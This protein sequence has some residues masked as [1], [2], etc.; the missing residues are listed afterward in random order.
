MTR[1]LKPAA[2]LLVTALIVSACRG[3]IGPATVTP[4]IPTARPAGTAAFP[5]AEGAGAEAVG[6]RGGRVIEVTSL[7]DIGAGTLREAIEA[8]GPRIVVFRVGGII[9]LARPLR[10]E[11]PYLTIAGQTAPGGGITL[12][13]T[14]DGDGEM[15]IIQNTH[16]IVIRYLRIRRGGHGEPGHGQINI[17]VESGAHDVMVDHVSV[18]WTLDEN[19]AVFRNI[20]DDA[21][22]A[23]WPTIYNV[24]LQRSIMAE[25]L[26]PH[27]KGTQFG[28]EFEK[29]GWEGVYDITVHHNLYA[30]NSHRNP[31]VG[32]ARTQV[33]NNVVYN[34][35]TKLGETITAT[36]ADWIGNYFKPGPLS[37]E[38]RLL[39]HNAF[40]KGFPD[41]PYP[42]P[43]LYVA[44]NASPPLFSD[45][46]E[47]NW[48]MYRIHYA[49][50]PI[51]AEFRRDRPLP[52]LPIPVS[53][54]P[55]SEA[56]TSVLADSGANARLD[57]LGRW[58][59]NADAVDTR[60]VG[61]VTSNT[62]VGG[63]THV[64]HED[65]VGGYPNIE[66]GTACPDGDHD[67]MPD[68]WESAH[69][70]TDPDSFDAGE[71][72]LDPVYT[73]IEVLLNGALPEP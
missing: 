19:I 35:G 25:G 32:S 63:K 16:D 36:Q 48:K 39:V 46:A 41:R 66:P 38:Q 56:F 62:G 23:T 49:E 10:I 7:D 40:P 47:D 21:D 5:G 53:V 43:S 61:E 15:I 52:P 60:L 4:I 71:Y 1:L 45:S 22:A 3:Q 11:N 69:G 6:G 64:E 42:I 12:R 57:C 72:D 44:G 67:G 34:W 54:Q 30:N 70:R 33:I 51:P 59:A 65:E 18:S 58:V 17:L 9:E 37:D 31:G 27:S 68:E 2:L 13:G 24:T 29:D 20:P 55:A 26:H 50:D 28:G 14:A 73:N 8:E